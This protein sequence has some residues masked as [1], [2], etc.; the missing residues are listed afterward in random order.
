MCSVISNILKVVLGIL[1][2][3]IILLFIWN[4]KQYR[5]CHK[6]CYSHS[7]NSY[8]QLT[9]WIVCLVICTVYIAADHK[10]NCPY[11]NAIVCTVYSEWCV[12]AIIQLCSSVYIQWLTSNLPALC[13]LWPDN[14]TIMLCTSLPYCLCTN[15]SFCSKSPEKLSLLK[16]NSTDSLTSSCPSAHSAPCDLIEHSSRS[17]KRSSNGLGTST[18]SKCLSYEEM[19][20]IERSLHSQQQT[21][22]SSSLSSLDGQWKGSNCH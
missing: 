1:V 12:H 5:C 20:D 6:K 16:S 15:L 18:S 22:R 9:S 8:Q 4:R 14:L 3:R 17:S 19:E 2:K 10:R 13:I 11:Q 7:Q 21:R